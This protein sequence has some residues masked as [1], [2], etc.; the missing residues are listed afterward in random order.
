[1]KKIIGSVLLVMVIAA[2]VVGCKKIIKAIFPGLDVDAPTITVSLPAIPFVPPSEA[3]IATFKQHFNLDS[4]VKAQTNGAFGATD[5]A[6]VQVKQIAFNL[7]NADP[8]NNLANFESVR[9]TFSSTSTTSVAE[10]AS[11]KFPDTFADS[12]TYTSTNP[13]ELISYLSGNE[14]TYDV[15]GKLRRITTKPLTLTVKVTLRVR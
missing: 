15:Y 5:V 1:M 3:H 9:F 2:G 11:I 8:Q 14:L 7:L 12:Y 4:I 13:P 10:V 6:S